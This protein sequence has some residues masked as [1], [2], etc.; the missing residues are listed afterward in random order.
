[1]WELPVPLGTCD[2]T[3][4]ARSSDAQAR[5]VDAINE[6]IKNYGYSV[7]GIGSWESMRMVAVGEQEILDKYH[8]IQD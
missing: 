8:S 5:M 3:G 4:M 6:T 7:R 1:M 2:K